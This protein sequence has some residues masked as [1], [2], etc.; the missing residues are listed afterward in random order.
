MLLQEVFV[1]DDIKILTTLAARGSL[2]HAQY[3]DSGYLGGELLILSRFPII[4]TRCCNLRCHMHA[5]ISPPLAGIAQFKASRMSPPR[6]S[7]LPATILCTW[8]ADK[9]LVHIPRQLWMAG[10]RYHQY[11]ASGSPVSVWEGDFY[12]G[13]GVA[14]ACLTT[15]SGPLHVYNTHT[16]ANYNHA[17]RHSDVA[18]VH[19]IIYYIIYY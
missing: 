5:S 9:G 4:Y 16:C 8:N 12:A 1:R 3:F 11:T 17:F 14:M 15:P 2:Q 19:Y 6:L 10:N 13:K 7:T 18:G